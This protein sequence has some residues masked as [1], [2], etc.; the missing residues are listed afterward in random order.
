MI[1]KAI[2]PAAVIPKALCFDSFNYASKSDIVHQ[3]EDLAA[4][5]AGGFDESGTDRLEFMKNVAKNKEELILLEPHKE[6]EGLD[7]GFQSLTF[8]KKNPRT[9]KGL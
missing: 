6:A 7:H 5:I 2:A 3:G 9:Y 1:V 4:Y 8:E